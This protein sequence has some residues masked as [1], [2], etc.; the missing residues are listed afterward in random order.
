[1]KLFNDERFTFCK[2]KCILAYDNYVKTASWK[3]NW[4]IVH[5]QA[6]KA[7]NHSEWQELVGQL[8]RATA[9]A[10]PF[11]LLVWLACQAILV[12]LSSSMV[13]AFAVCHKGKQ[14]VNQ[15]RKMSEMDW[16]SEKNSYMHTDKWTQGRY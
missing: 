12:S 3:S 10:K 6:D 15:K 2:W 7:T 13:K 11:R 8:F 5:C 16:R 9:P 4:N 14:H 1:M